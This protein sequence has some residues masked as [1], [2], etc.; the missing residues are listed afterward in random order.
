MGACQELR[1]NNKP[2]IPA[3]LKAITNGDSAA[4]PVASKHQ[5]DL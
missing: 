3:A 2:L 5:L 1:S 4:V